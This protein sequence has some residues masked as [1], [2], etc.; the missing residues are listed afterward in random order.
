MRRILFPLL[1]LFVSF[2]PSIL[3]AGASYYLLSQ[4]TSRGDSFTD[5]NSS[6]TGTTV[7][8]ANVV[9]VPDA[10]WTADNVTFRLAFTGGVNN[11]YG[12]VRLL[13][14]P[15]GT[16]TP[17]PTPTPTSTL[18]PISG[19][20]PS[21]S[22]PAGYV[23]RWNQDFTQPSYSPFNQSG[24]VSLA[25]PPS[26]IWRGEQGGFGLF[27]S[28]FNGTEGDP[29]STSKGYLTIHAN[30]SA[31]PPYGGMIESSVNTWN[32]PPGTQLPGFM[33]ANAYWEAKLLIPGGDSPRWPIFWLMGS[34]ATADPA[35][36]QYGEIDISESTDS[37]QGLHIYTGTNNSQLGTFTPPA[38]SRGWHV[39]GC[40][41]QNVGGS[42]TVT[43]YIDGQMSHQFTGLSTGFSSPMSVILSNSFGPGEPQG[44]NPG[45]TNDMGVQYVRC[46][47]Q[48][49]SDMLSW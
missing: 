46:W 36:G 38:L 4:E 19:I 10:A 35:A 31:T 15:G 39:W 2:L 8:T 14:T 48:L 49:T 21:V 11:S 17:T 41:I 40:L 22:L 27:Y 9:T 26:S 24:N 20:Q 34:T 3:Q 43:I 44:A 37:Q 28:H 13:Y 25:G 5:V 47:T 1:S 33:A 45:W 18:T 12:P 23:L 29:F 42:S 6:S 30:G 7:T 32:K 16:P